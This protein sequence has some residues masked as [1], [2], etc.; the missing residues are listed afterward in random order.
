M[1]TQKEVNLSQIQGGEP[2]LLVVEIDE[3]KSGVILL[4]EEAVVPELKNKIGGHRESQVWYL[5]NGASNHM[6]G[7]R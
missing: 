4:N 2:A 3:Q 1:E 5:D 7:Q 6:T